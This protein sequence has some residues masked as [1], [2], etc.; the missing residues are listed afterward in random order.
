MELGLSLKA[1]AIRLMPRA[2][3]LKFRQRILF[4][5]I[6]GLGHLNNGAAGRYFEEARAELNRAVFAAASADPPPVLM[7]VSTTLEYLAE[8]RYPGEADVLSGVWSVG[9]TSL[10]Y[11]HTLLQDGACLA[12]SEAVMVRTLAG[13]PAPLA[14]RERE[15]L[16]LLQLLHQED[17]ER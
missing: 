7:L 11:A 10:V 3:P 8:G 1:Q 2:Y 4:S 12:L 6:D 13:Q 14:D 17:P 9:R 5:D 15:A 16:G